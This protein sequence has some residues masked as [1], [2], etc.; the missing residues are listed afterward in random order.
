MSMVHVQSKHLLD[1]RL[2]PNILDDR[3]LFV[4]FVEEKENYWTKDTNMS[5]SLRM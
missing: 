2:P 4:S 3:D 1:Y 5:R